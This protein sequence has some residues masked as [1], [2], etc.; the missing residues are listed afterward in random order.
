RYMFYAGIWNAVGFLALA[1]ALN[2]TSLIHVNALS[3][4]QVGMTVVAGLLLF[5]EALTWMTAIGVG[6]TI[7][8]LLLM[9]EPT[10]HDSSHA[11]HETAEPP[12][13]A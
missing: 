4:T 10:N 6:L 2:Q 8:G 3:A 7:L 12:G 1:K 9:R 13:S 5:D 11:S